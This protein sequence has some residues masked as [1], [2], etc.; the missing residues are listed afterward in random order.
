RINPTEVRRFVAVHQEGVDGGFTGLP[1]VVLPKSLRLPVGVSSEMSRRSRVVELPDRWP[2]GDADP[3]LAG[4]VPAVVDD[5]LER[6]FAAAIVT[7]RQVD[8]L[9]VA[10]RLADVKQAEQTDKE[11]ESF[12][13]A[14]LH[15]LA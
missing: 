10:H 3:K 7:P 5:A 6:I 9:P 11:Q 8:V 4:K 2:S 1:L 12:A 15:K 14:T 13:R